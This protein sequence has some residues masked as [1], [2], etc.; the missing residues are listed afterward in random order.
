[1]LLITDW[2]IDRSAIVSNE[3]LSYSIHV[4]EP[5]GCTFCEIVSTKINVVIFA[6]QCIYLLAGDRLMPQFSVKC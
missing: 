1:M 4:A 3:G 2:S 5:F 6:K